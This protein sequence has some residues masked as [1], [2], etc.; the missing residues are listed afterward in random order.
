LQEV[1]RQKQQHLHYY[2]QQQWQQQQQ[3]QQQQWQQSFD[4]TTGY[5][6]WF[7]AS[8]GQSAWHCP[9]HISAS[10]KS[11]LPVTFSVAP[12][13]ALCAALQELQYSIGQT[14]AARGST[15]SGSSDADVEFIQSAQVVFCTLS[16]AGRRDLTPTL[17]MQEPCDDKNGGDVSQPMRAREM[18]RRGG[19]MLRGDVLVVDES[20][21]A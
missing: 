21:Q 16:T 4:P 9:P 12:T 18:R 11:A 6:Y 17:H 10:P 13:S 5:P 19:R 20:G 15:G 14:L 8:T 2:Q 7:N 3:Q 1:S